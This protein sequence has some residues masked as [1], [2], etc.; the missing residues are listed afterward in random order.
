MNPILNTELVL[1]EPQRIADGGG[2]FTTSWNPIG[3][4]AAEGSHGRL[5]AGCPQRF[6]Q[7]V[8]TAWPRGPTSR[9][10]MRGG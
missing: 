2:G 3:S 7:L 4:P 5:I 6:T 8:Y 1:E 9:P 10:S